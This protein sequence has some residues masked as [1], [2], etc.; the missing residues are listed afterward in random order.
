MDTAPSSWTIPRDSGDS[1]VVDGSMGFLVNRIARL[2]ASALQE[3]LTPL[4]LTIGAF[5]VMLALWAEDGQSQRVI[6]QRLP[7]DE[8]TLVRTLDRMERDGLVRRAR[9]TADRR[10]ILVHLTDHGLA[11]K[12]PALAAA[13]AVN[14]A[15]LGGLAPGEADAARAI[16]RRMAESLAADGAA[17]QQDL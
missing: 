16:M 8:T 17:A 12:E 10:R 7:L 11:L 4:G 3:R 14:A 2:F 9:D 15:A 5:P 13:D 6:A 1:F